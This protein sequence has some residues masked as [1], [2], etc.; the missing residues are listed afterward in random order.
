MTEGITAYEEKPREQWLFDY[1][2]QV[3]SEAG[4]LWAPILCLLSSSMT[5]I[6]L[7]GLPDSLMLQG[8]ERLVWKGSAGGT[9]GTVSRDAIQPLPWRIK[10]RP[11][12]LHWLQ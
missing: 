11:F 6:S 10:G 12:L 1:P 2:A 9:R 5:S 4:P 7:L 3:F 8:Q